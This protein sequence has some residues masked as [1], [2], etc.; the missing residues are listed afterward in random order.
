MLVRMLELE[1]QYATRAHQRTS[2]A[3]LPGSAFAHA[4][5]NGSEVTAE[6]YLDALGEL[7]IDTRARNF[8][9]FQVCIA[10]SACVLAATVAACWLEPHC[11]SP[12]HGPDTRTCCLQSDA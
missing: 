9:V 5:V 1:L 10:S 6:Q 3:C 7:N 4:Q 11:L 12:S 8:L 2:S